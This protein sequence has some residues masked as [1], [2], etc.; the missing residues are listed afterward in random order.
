MHSMQM[1]TALRKITA[2]SF[3]MMPAAISITEQITRMMRAAE[4]FLETFIFTDEIRQ[5]FLFHGAGC[6][7]F[8]LSVRTDQK[9]SR[10]RLNLI[11]L[12]DLVVFVESAGE[13]VLVLFHEIRTHGFFVGNAD[14]QKYEFGFASFGFELVSKPVHIRQFTPARRTPCCPEVE[15]HRFSAVIGKSD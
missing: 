1:K 3:R 2:L 13:R 7:P 10:N 8:D 5:V 14:S 15:K 6:H 9:R 12:C 4:I 11:R